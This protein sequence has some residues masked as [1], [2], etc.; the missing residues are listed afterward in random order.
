MLNK[1]VVHVPT[2]DLVL[3]T[4]N[5]KEMT[6]RVAIFLSLIEQGSRPLSF[7]EKLVS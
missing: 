7:H 3:A 4:Y 2:S 1:I 6:H 5:R